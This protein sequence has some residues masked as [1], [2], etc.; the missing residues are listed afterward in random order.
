VAL[1]AILLAP[2][3]MHAAA[4]VGRLVSHPDWAGPKIR[5]GKSEK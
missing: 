4:A 5:C 1:G 2:I 3:V